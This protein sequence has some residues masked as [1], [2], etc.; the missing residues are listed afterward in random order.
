[1]LALNRCLQNTWSHPGAKAEYDINHKLKNDPRIT[2]IG[3]FIRKMSIDELPQ[4]INV[5]QGEMSLVGPRPFMGEELGH[6]DKRYMLYTHVSQPGVTGLWQISGG[7]VQATPPA[8]A[9]M[10]ITCATGPSGWIFTSSSEPSQWS[11]E[12][13]GRY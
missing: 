5:L 12:V 2:R 6:Y 1:M 11:C 3:K 10:T 9:W 8:S 4:L 13:G 7:S